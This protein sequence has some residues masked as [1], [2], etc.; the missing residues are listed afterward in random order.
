M[1]NY[2]LLKISILTLILFSVLN[3]KK[4]ADTTPVA[5]SITLQ[6]D[7]TVKGESVEIEQI[8]Y[9]SQAGHNYSVVNLKYYLSEI[10]LHKKDGSTFSST[11]V[12]LRD[13]HDSSTEQYVIEDIP[14]G[15]YTKLSFIFGLDET[16]NVDG[17]LENTVENI[18][19]EW[20]I[21]GDQGYHYMKFEGRY[22]SLNTGVIRSFNVH[23]GATMG[24]QNYIEITLPFSE[25]AVRS[26]SWTIDISMD[27]N[28]WFQNP[29]TFD[30]VGMELIMMNQAAQEIIKANGATVFSIKSVRKN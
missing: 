5:S 10:V 12:H 18:N 23:T 2:T 7:H 29:N 21:P 20:P 16:T 11:K 22:D 15:D 30:F 3:C 24:N 27:L 13:I 17:G 14:D 6:L 9:L 26:N 25:T 1:K 4:D 8:K 19:M 28:E